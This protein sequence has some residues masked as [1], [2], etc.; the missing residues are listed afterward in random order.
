MDITNTNLPGVI[1]IQP[2]LCNDE[3]GFFI[4]HYHQQRYVEQAGLNVTFVQDNMSRSGQGIIR[5]LHYQW[6]HPQGK[7]VWVTQGRA[8]DVIVDIRHGSPT[9]AQS[10]TIELD[11][12]TQQQVY[13]PPGFAHGFCT[14]APVVDFQYKCT[15]VYDPTSEMTIQWDDPDLNIP[16]PIHD[17]V[18][19]EHDKHSWR[20]CDLRPDQLPVYL[21]SA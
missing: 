11:A 19:S 6:P 10:V 12:E 13:I 3:R 4:E 7:L 5:G 16:W 9:F 1:L 18:L 15:A 14:L 20:L 21:E 17:P 8:F 2:N